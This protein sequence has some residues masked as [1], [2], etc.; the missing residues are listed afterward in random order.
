MWLEYFLTISCRRQLFAYCSA[1]IVEV[2]E[3]G[4]AGALARSARSS[5]I[6]KPVLPSLV[7]CHVFSSPALREM[8]STVDATMKTL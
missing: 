3:D 7:H 2:K 5:S 8:T 4:R 6:S 1:L